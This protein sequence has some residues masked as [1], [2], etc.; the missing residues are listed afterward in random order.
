LFCI[1]LIVCFS[2]EE[3]KEKEN[4]KEHVQKGKTFT[5]GEEDEEEVDADATPDENNFDGLPAELRMDEYDDDDSLGGGELDELEDEE[6]AVCFHYL[7]R[8]I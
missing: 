6:I 5:T 8:R 4:E 7:M 3:I 1:V 2:I